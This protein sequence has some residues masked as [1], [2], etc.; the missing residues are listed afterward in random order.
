VAGWC[1]WVGAVQGAWLRRCHRSGA[2]L[3]EV[4]RRGGGV[5]LLAVLLLLLFLPLLLFWCGDGARRKATG[6]ARVSRLRLGLLIRGARAGVRLR[7]GNLGVR[8]GT[9]GGIAAVRRG[10]VADTGG[11]AV[12]LPCR[13]AGTGEVR[14]RPVTR[15]GAEAQAKGKARWLR[16]LSRGEAGRS[17]A[18]AARG[19]RES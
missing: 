11:V 6:V 17:A 12:S 2:G 10:S 5:P 18:G 8:A 4:L 16:G 9:R 13:G 15:A 14:G 7:P 1:R 3:V 19:G